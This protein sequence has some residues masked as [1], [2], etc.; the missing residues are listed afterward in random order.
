MFLERINALKRMCKAIHENPNTNHNS[1][2]VHFLQTPSS[3]AEENAQQ[4]GRRKVPRP[5][6]MGAI[7]KKFFKETGSNKKSSNLDNL[8]ES[9]GS[10]NSENL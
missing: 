6:R 8:D 4:E 9:E 3:T 5:K 2:L 7:L 1:T 10:T